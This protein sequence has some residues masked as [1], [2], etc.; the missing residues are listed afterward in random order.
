MDVVWD[1]AVN[2]MRYQGTSLLNDHFASTDSI[3]YTSIGQA[4][5]HELIAISGLACA[6]ATKALM[7][8]NLI[9]GT[10]VLYGTPAEESTSGK[11]TFVQQGLV[12]TR[13]DVAMMMQV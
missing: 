4:C 10:V 8:N 11:I 3:S 1:S 13:V 7:E 9:Q 12:D 6:L 2:T 5:G